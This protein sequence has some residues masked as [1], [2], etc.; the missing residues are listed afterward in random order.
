[1]KKDSQ[2]ERWKLPGVLLMSLLLPFAAAQSGTE[3]VDLVR[4]SGGQGPHEGNIQVEVDGEW[5]YVCDD[6]FGFDEA[7]IV[8]KELGYDVAEAFTR[9]NHFGDNSAAWRRSSVK[10]WLSDVNC[11]LATS[12]TTC[13]SARL[14]QHQCGP[15]EIAGVSCR[16]EEAQC[17]ANLFPCST[18]SE[19]LPRESVCDNVTDCDDGSDEAETLCLD[20]GV[21]R[22]TSNLA[23]A[24]IPGA[25]LGLVYIKF[26]GVWGT[27]CDTDFDNNDAK[28]ICRSLGYE[29]GWSLA[30]SRGYFGVGSEE[31]PI[32]VGSPGCLGDEEW[33]GQC[34]PERSGEI[35]CAHIEDASVFCYDGEAEVRLADGGAQGAAGVVEMRL[36]GE[37]GAVCDSRFDDFDAWVV[38]K[39]L[40][41]NGDDSRAYKQAGGAARTVWQMHLDCLGHETHVQ[42]CRLRFNNETCSSTAGVVCS[43]TS[44]TLN[45]GLQSLLPKQCGEAEDASQFFLTRLAK[46]R[47]GETPTRFDHPWLVSLR[48]QRLGSAQEGVLQC[49]GTIIS[50]Y[51][52]VTAAHCLS[53]LG[54]LNLVVRVGDHTANLREQ[55]EEEY[56]IDKIWKHEEFSLYSFNDNDVAL[57]KV[58]PKDGRGIRFSSKVMPLCLPHVGE[59]YEGLQ[60]CS[61]VGWG[62]TSLLEADSNQPNVGKIIIRPDHDC[63]EAFVKGTN[64]FTSSF[65]CAGSPLGTVNSCVGDSGGPFSCRRPGETKKSLYGIVSFGNSCKPFLA[66]DSLTRVTKY[67][68]WIYDKMSKS[69]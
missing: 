42:Q 57:L 43:S 34:A 25:A 48:R 36:G 62:P 47:F 20:V 27:V 68:R 55:S 54:S 64:N 22:L 40:G 33:I 13:T 24:N 14:G 66:P 11:S 17:E 31:T 56:F 52:I 39:M 63:E 50:E 61:I 26:E 49:G 46:V 58:Q 15:T 59:S 9:N 35:F 10:F 44:G 51:Y 1:M 37:W 30:F 23:N 19:C 65:V 41:Y 29:G 5:G 21:T 3:R 69:S 8:C 53:H 4:L 45:S 32:W 6:G 60:D 28:V 67:L 16:R 7:D 18:G 38:C 12:L 2:L